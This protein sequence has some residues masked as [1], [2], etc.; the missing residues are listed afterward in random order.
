[1]RAITRRLTALEQKMEARRPDHEKRLESHIEALTSEEL[2]IFAA[3][4]YGA[5]Y[6]GRKTTTEEAAPL[7]YKYLHGEPPPPDFDIMKW[8]SERL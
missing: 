2:A 7:L 5:S 6:C 3:W 1:M 4:V 8:V